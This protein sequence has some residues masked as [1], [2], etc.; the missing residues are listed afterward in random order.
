MIGTES[1][2]KT[3]AESIPLQNGTVVALLP[4]PPP[5]AVCRV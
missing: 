5:G 4:H 3:A 1:P 2:F